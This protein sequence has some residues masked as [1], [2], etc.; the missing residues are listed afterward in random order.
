M[1]LR[2]D[3]KD[4]KNIGY[5]LGKIIL[6]LGITMLVPLAAGAAFGEINPMLDF[7]IGSATAF[8]FGLLLVK[9]C[10][11]PSGKKDFYGKPLA[12]DL[13]W[14]QG[15]IVV[16]LSWIVAMFLGAL[17]LYLS[18]HWKS[19]LDACFDSMSG[20]AT[21]GLALVQ[22]L[23]HLS[24]T[25]NLW[26]HLIMFIG[27]QG[28][29][30]VALSFL[31]KGATGAFRMYVGE[32][33]D[34]K[35]LPNVINT[36]RF[37]WL[38]SIVF[39]VLGTIAL[40]IVGTLNGMRPGNAYFHGACVF[41]AAFDTGG[42]APQSQN[43]LYY[44]SLPFEVVTIIIMILG[45][46]NFKLHY[47][48]WTGNRK[49]IFKNIETTALFITLFV[50]FFITAAGL[51][52]LNTYPTAITLFRKGFYQLVSGHTGTGFMT[53]YAPQFIKEWNPLALVA[54]ICAMGLGG[55]VCSTT[56]AIKMLRLGIVFKAFIQDIKRIILPER[57]MVMKKF[58]HI[59]DVFLE[60]KQVRSACLVTLAYLFLY[61][62]GA[63]VGMWCGYPFLESLFESTSA[64]ANV[65]LSC[66]VTDIAMPGAL[67]VTYIFQMWI[68]RLEFMAVFTLIGFV[69]AIVKGKR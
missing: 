50:T 66:G 37:I 35:I 30:I 8:I 44:H 49:E 65:G 1:V 54:I 63:I 48:I 57:A 69:V 55:A 39:L 14:M 64:A 60:D 15:M 22:D 6:G 33:R 17:P 9:I 62:L 56:G 5:Y 53:I 52:H 42:F 24:Y 2:P 3:I 13:N 27:G 7:L 34:E 29:V 26:R 41:M 19:F 12:S 11:V 31:V 51:S 61:G 59:K 43:I 28:I 32:A 16:A 46:L 25:H 4:I 38:V 40:G 67:K 21:T 45:A 20:F 36:S 10:F 18:G 47:H 23:D 68:G 58:H